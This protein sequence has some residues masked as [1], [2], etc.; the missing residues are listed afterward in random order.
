MYNVYLSGGGMKGAYQ[1]GFFK[2]VYREYPDFPIKNI[3][4]MSIGSINALPIAVKKMEILSSY[5]EPENSSPILKVL[6]AWPSVLDAI[7]NKT[8]FHSMNVDPFNKFYD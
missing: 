2:Q 7:S 3:Y 4:C 5:W 6:N 8:L 1:Y